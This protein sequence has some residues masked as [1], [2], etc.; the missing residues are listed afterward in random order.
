MA[1]FRYSLLLILFS[2]LISCKK[3][4]EISERN[5]F[6]TQL[7]EH[8]PIVTTKLLRLSNFQKQIVSNGK[9]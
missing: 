5:N 2:L 6:D 4:N 3:S 8:K 1:I 7:N 9:I